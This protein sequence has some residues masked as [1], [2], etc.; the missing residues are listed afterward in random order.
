MASDWPYPIKGYGSY[1]E[2]IA[3]E[4]KK[5][6]G[7]RIDYVLIVTP[8]HVHFDPAMKCI[9]AGIPVFLEKPITV[10]L[11]QATT[12]VNKVKEKKVP[13]GVAHTYLGALDEPFRAPHRAQRPAGRSA[14][15]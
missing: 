7:E 1:D 8:N 2:M 5:P 12:L 13:F 3:E 6:K 14:L 10:N 15:G 11:E 4:S 9:E